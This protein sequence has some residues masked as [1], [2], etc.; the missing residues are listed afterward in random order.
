VEITQ[1]VHLTNPATTYSFY[2]GTIDTAPT[3]G[4]PI[5]GGSG[6][7]TAKA[8]LIDELW[9]RHYAEVIDATTG[10]A[11]QVAIWDIV[12]DADF[13]LGA[14]NFKAY[15]NS[16]VTNQAT[17]WLNDVNTNSSPYTTANLIALKSSTY[18]DQITV[19]P[20]VGAPPETPLPS[21]AAGAFLLFAGMGLNQF[22]RPRRC[23]LE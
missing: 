20:P 5:P 15:G 16:A 21:T 1:D 13:N 4:N 19:N 17:A 12:Y 23:N 11:F 18:Q 14:G 8:A 9:A 3:P 10:A 2:T 22:R 7:G 6:M